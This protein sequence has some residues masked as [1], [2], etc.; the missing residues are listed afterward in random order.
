MCALA[1]FGTCMVSETD[2]RDQ[3]LYVDST[4]ILDNKI[5]QQY[6]ASDLDTVFRVWLEKQQWEKGRIYRK[7]LEEPKFEDVIDRLIFINPDEVFRFETK[8]GKKIPKTNANGHREIDVKQV[9]YKL[10]RSCQ[11]H[12]KKQTAVT[13][14]KDLEVL[15]YPHPS[16]RTT[17]LAPDA[18]L[19]LTF[20]V[21]FY[22]LP[23]M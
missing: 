15:M 23:L 12:V 7:P 2:Y 13:N 4:G 21:Q 14:I 16:P 19:A 3:E 22:L 1:N 20:Q 5:F 18:F 8:E 9:Y 17:V 11:A 10:I 6:G